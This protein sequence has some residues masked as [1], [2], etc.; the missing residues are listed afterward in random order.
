MAFVGVQHQN[1][2]PATLDKLRLISEMAEAWAVESEAFGE[3]VLA[4]VQRAGAG[5]SA[6]EQVCAWA[7]F[8][9]SLPYRRE[10][11]EKFRS[12]VLTAQKGGDCDD[13][14]ILAL[15]GFRSLGLQCYPECFA[16]PAGNGFHVRARVG[17][18]P[19][20]PTRWLV[21]D[22][23]WKSEREWAT[24]G[25]I[26]VPCNHRPAKAS[27]WPVALSFLAGF[28]VAKLLTWRRT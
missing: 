27:L 4:V 2:E 3:F 21:V 7:D 18:P 10:A 1:G 8:C 11:E 6:A 22:P 15:A 26:Q 25:L 9:E 12:P 28:G 20:E 14:T 24:K 16:P 13:L 19:L 5:S 23:V 17:L